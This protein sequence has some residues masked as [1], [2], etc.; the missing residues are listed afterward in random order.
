MSWGVC[1]WRLIDATPLNETACN[2]GHEFVRYSVEQAGEN[3]A[4]ISR[5]GHSPQLTYSKACHLEVV[6]YL[7]G[8]ED[9]TVKIITF[10]RGTNALCLAAGY[11]KII[12]VKF[13]VEN[14]NPSLTLEHLV[15]ELPIHAAALR[16]SSEVVKYLIAKF[17]PASVDEKNSQR[18]TPLV[19]ALDERGDQTDVI[20]YLMKNGGVTSMEYSR[21]YNKHNAT[22]TNF[23]TI[24]F[25]LC[26]L[27]PQF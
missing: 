16:G 9:Q 10:I 27:Y 18:L 5:H 7:W 22:L 17:D 20:K 19:F 3:I 23:L 4:S 12:I 14:T 15:G 8:K 21:C 6:K 1:P 25:R 13:L 11:G 2:D 24:I 26:N